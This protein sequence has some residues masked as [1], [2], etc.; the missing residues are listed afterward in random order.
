L[1]VIRYICHAAI[2]E[3]RDGS[4]EGTELD[5]PSE[6]GQDNSLRTVTMPRE[7][8]N[9]TGNG[10]DGLADSACRTSCPVPG[11]PPDLMTEPE[12][13]HFLRIPQVSNSKDY[14]NVIENLKRMHQLPRIHICGKSLYPREA[15]REWIKR[16]TGYQE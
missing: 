8:R 7:S 12:L 1:L 11:S 4:E 15:I 3:A 5:M 13:I 9:S 14:H 10:F 16:K 2:M 6:R